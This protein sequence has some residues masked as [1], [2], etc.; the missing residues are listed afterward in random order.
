MVGG[1]GRLVGVGEDAQAWVGIA[2][3]PP[4]CRS[5]RRGA[6]RRRRRRAR[7]RT[8]RR[9][10]TA[11]P[12]P[13]P[14]SPTIAAS[15]PGVS[16]VDSGTGTIPAR[17]A[18]RKN[19]GNASSSS[20]ISAT[21]SP[22]RTSSALRARWA[23]KTS[24]CSAAVVGR[25]AV[26][27]VGDAVA[28]TGFDVPIEQPGC[29]VVRRHRH[30]PCSTFTPG[31]SRSRPA[32][33]GRPSTARPPSRPSSPARRRRPSATRRGPGRR[34]SAATHRSRRSTQ[35]RR[36]VGRRATRGGRG[37]RRRCG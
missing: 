24:R 27:H 23:R 35:R 12:T 14:A 9:P 15:S 1:D 7:R 32:W 2:L 25:R 8:A 11:P 4:A 10:T 26:H 13:A 22:R 16:I 19:A 3:V 18:P 6:A 5:R 17:R 31:R 34:R 28:V 20:T 33:R 37:T 30:P 36:A 29:C 21:R